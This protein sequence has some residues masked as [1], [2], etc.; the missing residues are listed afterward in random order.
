[1]WMSEKDFQLLLARNPKLRVHQAHRKRAR[2]PAPR[3]PAEPEFD[4]EAERRYYYKVIAPALQDGTIA[5]VTLHK[6]FE[7]LPPAENNGRKYRAIHYSPDF[8]IE[9]KGGRTDVVE[10]KGRKIK[11][12]RPDY[13]I[14]RL[15]FIANFCNPNNWNF[16][17]VFDDEI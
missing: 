4:S 14:R 10:I 8:F 5:K 1:M 11:K 3:S 12:L 2:P 9:Y 13:P 16:A 15:L 7:L 6:T 17:E